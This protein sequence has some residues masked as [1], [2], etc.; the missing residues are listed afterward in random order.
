MAV[1]GFLLTIVLMFCAGC[2][3][4]KL[5]VIGA[6]QEQFNQLQSRLKNSG[7]KVIQKNDLASQFNQLTLVSAI[8][9]PI[10][11][12]EAALDEVVYTSLAQQGNQFYTESA[13]L[14]FPGFTPVLLDI[15]TN[16]CNQYSITL[17]TFK[18]NFF[19]IA[20]EKFIEDDSGYRLAKVKDIQG[21]FVMQNEV[22]TAHIDNQLLFKS[23]LFFSNSLQKN[24]IKFIQS[25]IPEISLGCLVVKTKNHL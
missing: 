21:S 8:S 11:I 17:N 1:K 19:T 24:T 10:S 13:G 15:Y 12:V 7:I 6:N 16:T 3:Q 5:Y 25:N 18:D 4:H 2:S 9:F 22:M 14:Y 23:E 20:V